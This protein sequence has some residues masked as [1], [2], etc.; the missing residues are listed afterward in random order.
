VDEILARLG[1]L[2]ISDAWL[3]SGCLFQSV[4][5]ILAGEKPTR[6]IK[7]YDVFYFD[8]SDPS[9]D[10]EDSV[11]HRAAAIFADLDCEID[12]R[13]QA[14][15]H[16]WYETEFGVGGYPQ[17]TKSTDG[18][19]NFLA[20]CCMVGVR[21]TDS[22][23]VNLYAPFGTDDVFDCVM[24]QNPWYPNAPRDCYE[25]KA[26]RWSALWPALRVQPCISAPRESLKL[27]VQT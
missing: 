27:V 11:N 1:E 4:W 16:I 17:L 26:E 25:K 23:S 20:V 22:G 8:Q 9:A 3:V 10:A 13:N 18:I 7:D 14:R 15:V 19:D 24:R 6:A 2:D 5:N 12:V 21:K